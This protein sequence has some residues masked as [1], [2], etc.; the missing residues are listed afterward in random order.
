MSR[1]INE[2]I[3][4]MRFDNQDFNKNIDSSENKL[5]SFSST[6]TSLPSNISL[7]LKGLLSNTSLGDILNFA[8]VTSGIKGIKSEIESI[9]NPIENVAAKAVNAV[10]G[11]IQSTITQ[12]NVGGKQR[13]LDIAEAKFQIEGLGLSVENFMEAADYAVSGTAYGL[14][15][16]AKVAAQL[17]ASGV[18]ELN[19]LKKALRAVSGVAAMTNRTYSDMGHIF[20]IVASNGKLMTEQ[21]R[22]FSYA[23][24]NVTATL[25]KNLGVTEHEIEE[26]VKAGAIDFKTFYT[27]MDEAFGEHAKDANKTFTG[28]ISNIKAALNRIGEGIW[29][30]I[31]EKSID[32]LNTIRMSINDFKAQLTSNEVFVNFADAVELVCQKFDK[33]ANNIK[34]VINETP[35][36]EEVSK[37][38]NNLFEMAKDTVSAFNFDYSLVTNAIAKDFSILVKK[39]GEVIDAAKEAFNEVFGLWNMAGKFQSFVHWAADLLQLLDNIKKEDVKELFVSWFTA[40]KSVL[41]TIKDILG[42]SKDNLYKVFQNVSDAVV[43]LINNLKLSDERIDK[44]TR[45]FKGLASAV[46]IV[47][48]LLLAIYNNALK[49]LFSYINPVVDTLLSA[50][51]T[52]GDTLYNLRNSIK[53]GNVFQNFFDDITEKITKV[54]ELAKKFGGKFIEIF[55]SGDESGIDKEKGFLGYI[56]DFFGKVV[57]FIKSIFED[58]KIEGIDLSPIQKFIDSFANLGWGEGKTG[59]TAEEKADKVLA[60]FEK[61]SGWVDKVK[62]I[63]DKVYSNIASSQLINDIS[64]VLIDNFINPIGYLLVN[65]MQIMSTSAS[66]FATMDSADKRDVLIS[67]FEHAEVVI[68]KIAYYTYKIV[69]EAKKTIKAL[70]GTPLIIGIGSLLSKMGGAIGAV[71]SILRKLNST[72]FNPLEGVIKSFERFVAAIGRLDI[73]SIIHGKEKVSDVIKAVAWLIVAIAAALVAIS[74]V[75]ENDLKRALI[76]LGVLLAVVGGIITTIVILFSAINRT[77]AKA[78]F[79]KDKGKSFKELLSSLEFFSNPIKGFAELFKSI[80]IA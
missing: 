50:T 71:S 11:V 27:A 60:F 28:A 25:A 77:S 53:E 31:I 76:T 68:V 30:P 67:F 51:S 64:N 48:M 75:P 59:S 14:N 38:L 19:E 10:S 33:F 3:V 4:K 54:L 62:E 80:A 18:S 46:D 12:I 45:T 43:K 37:V 7:G 34:K 63:L 2:N 13:A 73:S 69:K 57:E 15:E 35:L 32:T 24:L 70:E 41:E 52:V 21:I 58:F 44:I 49:P 29:T 8:A 79:D 20:T 17:G 1:I 72:N 6:L 55:F 66:G 61:L 9:A 56:A 22:S 42:I 65:V 47:K 78:K 23:G 26:M 39:I 16:A 40:L 74:L 5:K 36:L